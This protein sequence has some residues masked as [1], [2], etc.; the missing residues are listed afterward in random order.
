VMKAFDHFCLN[1]VSCIFLVLALVYEG[2]AMLLRDDEIKENNISNWMVVENPL[3]LPPDT[4]DM[5]LRV[6]KVFFVSLAVMIP[7]SLIIK[8]FGY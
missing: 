3:I 8:I 1:I 2:I 7:Y 6:V 4:L 5:L